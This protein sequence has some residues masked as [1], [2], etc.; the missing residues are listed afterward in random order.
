MRRVGGWIAVAAVLT[1]LPCAAAHGEDAHLDD[2]LVDAGRRVL[3]G[4]FTAPQPGALVVVPFFEG[5][6][7]C[8]SAAHA[9]YRIPLGDGSGVSF[10]SNATAVEALFDAAPGATGYVGLAVD[11]H[12]ATRALILMQE[13]AVALHALVGLVRGDSESEPR[14]ETGA[15]GLPYPIP[16]AG[17]GHGFEDAIEGRGI[18]LAH[19]GSFGEPR[20]CADGGHAALAFSRGD[21]P[22]SLG[23]GS[24]VHVVAL[25]DPAIAQFLPRP[26]EASTRVLEAN[27]YLARPGEDASRIREALDPAPAAFDVV[28]LAGLALGL[29]WV[30]RP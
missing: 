7:G 13:N 3:V 12:D 20:W 28:A 11:T 19:D 1:L 5:A 24:L 18:V 27:L 8:A 26:I 16:G 22:D 4:E 17:M 29:V 14:A 10:A 6:L 21:L 23:P 30:G 25:E 9:G 2:Q 15:L